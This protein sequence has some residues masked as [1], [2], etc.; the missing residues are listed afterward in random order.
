[1]IWE[2][3]IVGLGPA[4]LTCAI[5]LQRYG[6]DFVGFEKRSIGGLL[7]NANLVEN[8]LGF[9]NGISGKRLVSLM[10][11]Q[12]KTTGIQAVYEKV[13]LIDF[14]DDV[15]ILHTDSQEYFARKCVLATGT[16]PIEIDDVRIADGSQNN[17]FYEVAD[18]QNIKKSNIAII[19]SG[20]AAFDYALNLSESNDVAIYCR[21]N[22]AKALPL[23][24]KRAEASDNISIYYDTSLLEIKNRND[25]LSL[26]F[27]KSNNKYEI[28]ADAL[29][30][31][32]GRKPEKVRVSKNLENKYHE[33]SD[34][35]RL[36]EI[37]DIKNEL[38]RQTSI[39]SGDG[40]R[41]AMQIYNDLR[42]IK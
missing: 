1:M 21:S 9:P 3:A 27:V 42:G 31:A 15:F 20:D 19:G 8:Y 7:R 11:N 37:G 29:V 14:D 39:S 36:F 35:D 30:I 6:V 16:V 41:T 10:D 12:L 18:I 23:L 13:E 17:I 2:V 28:T 24:I 32:I 34:M 22:K 25:L 40:M 4:G 26:I 5:Q 33:L 38:F